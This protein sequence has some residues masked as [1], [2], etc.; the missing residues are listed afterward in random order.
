V[1]DCGATQQ[2]CREEPATRR[3]QEG[4]RAPNRLR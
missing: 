2:H 1:P 3:A 4:G